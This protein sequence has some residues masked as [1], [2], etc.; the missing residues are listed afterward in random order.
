MHADHVVP[1]SQGGERY[2][3]TNGEARC[4]AC[5][6]RKTRREQ[7]EAEKRKTV[8]KPAE[9]T[10]FSAGGRGNSAGEGGSN[11]PTFAQ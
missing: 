10:L 4:V 3:V 7:N 9:N 11:H 5:H 6:G 1:V 2:D 8:K